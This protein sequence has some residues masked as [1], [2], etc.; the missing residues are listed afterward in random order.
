MVGP[1]KTGTAGEIT[2]IVAGSD[3]VVPAA[4]AKTARIS[5]PFSKAVSAPVASV[6]EFHP[7]N[8]AQEPPLFTEYC[9][10]TV[11]GGAPVAAAVKVSVPPEYADWLWGWD[12][13][14]GRLV[15][16]TVR[17]TGFDVAVPAELV[18]TARKE[19]P[20]P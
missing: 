1:W 18:K 9:Q 15:A 6:L 17:V 13:T 10:V 5:Q 11:G 14:T 8:G 16:R 19:M 2:V 12:V 7:D 20:F 4:L 3:A